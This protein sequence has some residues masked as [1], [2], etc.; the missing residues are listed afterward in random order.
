MVVLLTQEALHSNRVRMD[1]EYALGSKKY[2]ERIIPVMVGTSV[3]DFG[4]SY[5]PWVLWSYSTVKLPKSGKQE[6]AI[7]QIADALSRAA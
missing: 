5:F 4:Q 1:I 7:K 2:K 6:K 3:N